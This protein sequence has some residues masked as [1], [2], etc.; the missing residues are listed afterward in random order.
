MAV[1]ARHPVSGDDYLYVSGPVESIHLEDHDAAQSR[2]ELEW[3]HDHIVSDL[4]NLYHHEWE[5]GDLLIWDNLLSIHKAHGDYGSE[6]R[7]LL[8]VQFRPRF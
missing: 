6:P 3:V 4:D 2:E 8:K 5:E 7:E 1:L